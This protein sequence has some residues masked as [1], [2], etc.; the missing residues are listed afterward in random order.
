M[1]NQ[2]K[3]IVKRWNNIGLLEGIE[4]DLSPIS[5]AYEQALDLLVEHNRR[6]NNDNTQ[7]ETALFPIIRRVYIRI[8]DDNEFDVF[9][10]YDELKKFMVE[11]KEMIDEMTAMCHTGMDAEA[12]MC[13]I[14]TD[15]YLLKKY[16]ITIEF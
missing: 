6:N 4:K 7:L 12:E 10:I 8:G 5:I 13:G 1:L 3:R 2:K 15:Y 11:K 14:F 9:D 16:N